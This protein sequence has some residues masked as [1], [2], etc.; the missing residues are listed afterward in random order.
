MTAPRD[1]ATV[2]VVI[3]CFNQ[4]R[5]LRSAIE[6]ALGQHP[7]PLE[8]I[9]VDDGSTDETAAL[10]ESLGV[11]VLTQANRGVSEAR[12]AGLVAARGDLVVFLDA[13]DELLAGALAHGAAALTAAD[14]LS[15]VVGRCQVMDAQGRPLHAGQHAI[16]PS[17]LYGEWLSRNFVWTPGAA[18]FRR[19]ALVRIGGFPAGRGPAADYAV[20]L[21]LARTNEIAAHPREVVRYR[22]HDASMSRDPA[23]MLRQTLRVLRE[24]QREAPRALRPAFARGR[25]TWRMWY[26]QQILDRLRADRKAGRF[27]RAQALAS[28][29]LMRHCPRFVAGEIIRKARNMTGRNA[30]SFNRRSAIGEIQDNG[31]FR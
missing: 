2:S 10:A 5:Y 26:G 1:R 24:E 12:N 18:M 28:V 20:Y 9:V 16:D 22:Q 21:R 8:C 25:E 30:V 19:A 31:H 15:A 29:T 13:D 4:A 6:S 14:G 17:N 23:L 27:G 11:I 7:P 3:P